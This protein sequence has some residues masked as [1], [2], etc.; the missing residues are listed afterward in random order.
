MHIGDDYL[1]PLNTNKRGR[2]QIVHRGGCGQ[3]FS[4]SLFLAAC[5]IFPL[6]WMAF[7]RCYLA[8]ALWHVVRQKWTVTCARNAYYRYRLV[9]D[10]CGIKLEPMLGNKAIC[11]ATV[12]CREEES[13]FAV[14]VNQ[15]RSLFW[16]WKLC[17]IKYFIGVTVFLGPKC[18]LS[19]FLVTFAWES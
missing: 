14:G 18:Q 8:F 15:S 5:L 3:R 17:G 16:M 13:E 6:W 12:V 9:S 19:F 11:F 4:F 7:Q 1:S 10:S 2:I